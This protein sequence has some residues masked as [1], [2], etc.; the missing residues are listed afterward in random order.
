[1]LAAH[2]PVLDPRVHWEASSA[3]GEFD[4]TILG[5]SP[6]PGAQPDELVDGYRVRRLARKPEADTEMWSVLFRT[7]IESITRSRVAWA[8][9]VLC[10][11]PFLVVEIVG[12]AL[13][14][15][16]GLLNPRLTVG[17]IRALAWRGGRQPVSTG[18]KYRRVAQKYRRVAQIG[19]VYRARIFKWT[20]SHVFAS[21]EVFWTELE[22]APVKPAI[23]HCNDLDTLLAGILMRIV[24]RTKV[25][26]DSHEYWPYSNVDAPG[27]HVR[28]FTFY[29]RL[30]ARRADYVLTVSDP[31]AA[32]LERKYGLAK[33]YSVPN[34]EP[35]LQRNTPPP[36]TEMSRIAAGR[37]K[38]LYQGN[39]A[40]ERGLDELLR[41]WAAIDRSKAAFFLRGPDNQWRQDLIA[42]AEELGVL[43]DGVHFID[44]VAEDELVDSA[45]EAD[46]GVIPYKTDSPGYRYACPNKLSQYM[47]AGI[48]VMT[49]NISYVRQVVSEADCGLWY[50]EKDPSTIEAAVARVVEDGRN[51]DQWKANALEYAK[52]TFNWQ[53]KGKELKEIYRRCVADGA[54]SAQM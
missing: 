50:D 23:V 24:H 52:S 11:A 22:R 38:F 33:V 51:V 43:D 3:A 31:L 14:F 15:V 26:Y 48:A 4:V 7:A 42:L 6:T 35:W 30:L 9:G 40:P 19:V 12:R 45:R 46:I 5:L 47:H 25:V 10:L 53:V 41:A 32:E 8:L 27:Y 28:F 21:A 18:S 17:V 39:F 20:L 44:A 36:V 54:A 13:A 37:T 49:N 29:E 34:A 16:A 1:M 2:D